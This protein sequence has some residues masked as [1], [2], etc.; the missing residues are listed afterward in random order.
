MLGRQDKLMPITLV[1]DQL[2]GN[3]VFVDSGNVCTGGCLYCYAVDYNSTPLISRMEFTS[4]DV[5]AKALKEKTSFSPGIYGTAISMGCYADPLHPSCISTTQEILP[6][7][8]A[9]G[10]PIQMASKCFAGSELLVH[11]IAAGQQYPGQFTLLVTVTSFS[12]A[13]E[14]EPGAP[15]PYERLQVLD[16]FQQAGINTALFIKPLLPGLSEF[17]IDTFVEAIL[18]FQ[19]QNCVIG[20][21]YANPRILRKF[22]RKGFPLTQKKN[23]QGNGHHFPND[24]KRILT[25]KSSNE[26]RDEYYLRLKQWID[27][28]IF[29]TS[30]C[31]VAKRLG[32]P[33]P[34][35]TW[36]RYPDLCV[37]C[38]DCEGLLASLS[39]EL[40]ERYD[41]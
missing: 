6:R 12:H 30:M 31:V 17:E 21:F 29:K 24:V 35:R 8:L 20:L 16:T 25:Q 1:V 5:A 18:K 26:Y 4:A 39:P 3:R 10:N 11:E 27:I 34:M 38:Q 2:D 28:S 9:F 15:S 19:I 23:G 14:L 7:M 40:Q 22:A 41:G 37:N 32:I 33:D 13:S 36:M